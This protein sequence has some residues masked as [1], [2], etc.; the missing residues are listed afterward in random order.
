MDSGKI[1]PQ[2]FG[3]ELACGPDL[4][5]I[6]DSNVS[7]ATD[8]RRHA[9]L[10]LAWTVYLMR[11]ASVEVVEGK[12][13]NVSCD[14]FYCLV[15]EPFAAGESIRCV[16]MIPAFDGQQPQSMISLECRARVVRVE[17]VAAGNGVACHIDDYKV[18]LISP[19]ARS[20]IAAFPPWST[21]QS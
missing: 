3:D 17:P 15:H 20:R 8:R 6:S 13:K 5:R 18:A 7:Y 10:P 1:S 12:T 19:D 9:R 4:M 2:V 14:G 21:L 11:P 16:I